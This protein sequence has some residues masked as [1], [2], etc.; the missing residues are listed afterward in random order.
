M[1]V[2]TVVVRISKHAIARMIERN[3]DYN[4]IVELI[5]TGVTCYKDH[6]RMWIYKFVEKRDDNLIC[7]AVS[8][9]R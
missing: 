1:I 7:A 5:E 4:T 2:F 6:T 9:R 3:I 8:S